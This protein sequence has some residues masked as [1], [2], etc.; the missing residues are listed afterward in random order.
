MH[1][2]NLIAKNVFQYTNVRCHS[3]LPGILLKEGEVMGFIYDE[4]EEFFKF[5]WKTSGS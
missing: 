5:L 4:E 2:A 3:Q 1:C